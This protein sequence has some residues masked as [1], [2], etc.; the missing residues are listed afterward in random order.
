MERQ[1]SMPAM[2]NKCG[3]LF[4]MSYD[5]SKRGSMDELEGNIIKKKGKINLC[6]E[7]RYNP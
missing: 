3:E 7:C 5:L 1:I 6:W 2:C 4:D